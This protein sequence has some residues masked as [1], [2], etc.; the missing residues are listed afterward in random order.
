LEVLDE[1]LDEVPIKGGFTAWK[2]KVIFLTCP[3]LPDEE[4][5]YR[6]Q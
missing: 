6:D 2:P 5:T 3:R 1:T 4:F